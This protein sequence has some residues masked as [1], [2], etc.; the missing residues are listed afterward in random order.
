MD[1]WDFSQ[2]DLCYDDMGGGLPVGQTTNL[3]CSAV[4]SGRYVSIQRYG[5][6]THLQNCEVQVIEAGKY[7]SPAY[8]IS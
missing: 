2:N 1:P 3:P 6:T 4:L 7:T 8:C 5:H